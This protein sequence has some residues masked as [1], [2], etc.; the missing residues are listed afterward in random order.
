MR[1]G[2]RRKSLRNCI[3]CSQLSL[4]A[5]MQ[6]CI[7]P[8]SPT[9]SLSQN[10]WKLSY[11][12]L[13]FLMKFILGGFDAH[14]LI[15]PSVIFVPGK[16]QAD[17]IEHQNT[18]AIKLLSGSWEQVAKDRRANLLNTPYVQN[19]IYFL[20]EQKAALS[21]FVTTKTMWRKDIKNFQSWETLILLW[22]QRNQHQNKLF[23]THI[24][25]IAIFFA[26][27]LLMLIYHQF[28]SYNSISGRMGISLP[29]NN[30]SF[31]VCT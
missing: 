27:D 14:F 16:V 1:C 18:L 30:L 28:Q 7:L 17:M 3:N 2:K 29:V 9:S 11:C 13:R 21:C 22:Y 19:L 31:L 12:H 24:P 23:G 4:E 25:T 15:M 8:S 6:S 10:V 26:I 20:T 5:S